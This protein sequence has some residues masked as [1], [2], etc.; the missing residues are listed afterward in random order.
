M[1]IM[2]YHLKV[3]NIWQAYIYNLDLFFSKFVLAIVPQQN[4]AS[5]PALNEITQVIM[6]PPAP[7]RVKQDIFIM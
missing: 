5:W 7:P 4:W 1:Y 6:V 3:A 2:V